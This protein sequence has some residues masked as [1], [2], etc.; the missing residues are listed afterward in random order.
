[1]PTVSSASSSHWAPVKEGAS[2]EVV[3]EEQDE[4]ERTRKRDRTSRTA[5]GHLITVDIPCT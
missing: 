5:F 4:R 1:M 3:D 2:G